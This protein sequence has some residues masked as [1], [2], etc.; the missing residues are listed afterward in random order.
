MSNHFE[1]PVAEAKNL[2]KEKRYDESAAAF[3]KI[4]ENSPNDSS[5]LRELAF[6]MRDLGQSQM[7][8]SLLADST[9]SETPDVETLRQIALILR[10]Q[11]RLDE[12][13]DFLL[14]ALAHAP[15]NQELLE[16]T[17]LLLKQLGRESE[18]FSGAEDAPSA[19]E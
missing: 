19:R 1:D 5:A 8:L 3:G 15:E 2:A 12:A 11:N 13:G 7:A 6:V 4:F 9:N 14:C 17:Q 16:E 18:L 10:A